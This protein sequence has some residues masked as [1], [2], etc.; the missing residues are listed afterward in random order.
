MKKYELKTFFSSGRHGQQSSPTSATTD[1]QG[2]RT[3]RQHLRFDAGRLSNDV[4]GGQG[5]R[6]VLNG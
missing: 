5:G 6:G 4:R 3:A 2:Q 1:G